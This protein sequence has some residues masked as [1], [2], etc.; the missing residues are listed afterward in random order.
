MEQIIGIDKL[1]PRIG[2]YLNRVKDGEVVIVTS[3]SEPKG[4]LLSY[5]I[6]KELKNLAERA[7]QLELMDMLNEIRE[8]A[9]KTGLTEKDVAEEIREARKCEQ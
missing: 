2:E 7:K 8:K 4:V 3:H 9:Q 1:R 6:Y 5:E